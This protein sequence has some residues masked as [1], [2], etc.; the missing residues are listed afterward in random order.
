MDDAEDGGP[1]LPAD[2][3]TNS[4][5][6]P[7]NVVVQVGTVV[8]NVVFT[9]GVPVRPAQLPR[10]PKLFVG[11]EDEL[12]ALDE[13][14]AGG[15][16]SPGT[17]LISA[18]NGIGGVGKTCLALCWAHRNLDRYPDGQLYID[19]RG[20]DAVADPLRP[21]VAVRAFL[22]A[23]QIPPQSIPVDLQAQAGL[24]RSLV[25]GKRMLIVLD[26]A[27]DTDQVLPLLPGHS[28]SSVLITS[29][30][31]LPVLTTTY[32][33]R[34]IDLRALAAGHA[35]EY[36]ARQWGPE[37]TTA[38]RSSVEALIDCCAGLPL[39]LR[40]V[41]ARALTAPS[42][43]LGV[44]AEE[45]LEERDRLSGFEMQDSRTGLRAVF[46]WSYR[47]LAPEDAAVLRLTALHTGREFGFP[48]LLALTGTTS[49]RLRRTLERLLSNGMLD[50]VGGRFTSHDLLHS[51]FVEL[52]R[53]VD[54]EE[55]RRMAVRRLLDHYLFTSLN[56][57]RKLKPFRGAIDA[58]S[59]AEGAEVRDFD[60]YEDAVAWFTLEY[61]N[62]I[63][64]V[65]RAAEEGNHDH[66]WK[67][68]W[69]LT[70]FCGRFG[71]WRDWLAIQR[72][73]AASAIA[74]GNESAEARAYRGM[75]NA[76]CQLREYDEALRHHERSMEI[77]RRTGDLN[78]MAGTCLAV[79]WVH[80][81]TDDQEKLL[82]S[83][84]QAAAL[85]EQVGNRLGRARAFNYLG[86]ALAHVEDYAEA[87]RHCEEALA[88]HQA[89]GDTD[90]EAHA[91]D[92]L[93]Y[94]HLMSGDHARAIEHYQKSVVLYRD[95]GDHYYEAAT[96]MR[97]GDAHHAAGDS[98][99]ALE[100]WELARAMLRQLEHPDQAEVEAKIEGLR[101]S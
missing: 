54:D 6:G 93:S 35:R 68:A 90:A 44:L 82:G 86:W 50:E 45:L 75:G 12:R 74:V 31:T 47:A 17:A 84:G 83:A 58:G 66:A 94:A 46:S 20:F 1:E 61:P 26:N 101:R 14:L 80:E 100:Q 48:A 22:D 15:T 28:S 7:A 21:A 11:R 88:V 9:S 92:S 37:R 77:W 10:A 97:L 38:D 25:A 87:V 81:Q 41:A 30:N 67:L 2:S 18:V 34:R 89:V 73:A 33:A 64:A 95:V 24:Y 42:Q 65:A 53:E 85:Y 23:F 5:T 55:F 56:A 43:P 57:D 70:T 99:K 4:V 98:A 62:L 72:I 49:S 3:I 91:L 19:L 16:D 27:R 79:S 36:L 96:L 71:H 76:H 40:I 29:R 51:Y 52:V 8:G 39:A 32:E 59:P 60:G 63:S 13:A 69:T 78:G